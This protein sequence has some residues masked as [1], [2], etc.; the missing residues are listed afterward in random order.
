MENL[1]DMQNFVANESPTFVLAQFA[2]PTNP[3]GALLR[4]GS[5]NLWRSNGRV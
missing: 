3:W 1:V 5:S 4:L 2:P